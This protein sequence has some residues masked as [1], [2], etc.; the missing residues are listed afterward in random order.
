MVPFAGDGSGVD[1]L[2][3]GQRN[4]WRMME[5]IGTPEMVGGA[6]K[7]DE[8]TTVDNIRNLLSFI[9]SRHQSLR[10]RIRIDPDGVP[11]QW[12]SESGE[13]P[14]TIID[15]PDDEDPAEVAEATREHYE[16]APFDI[17]TEWPV[18]MAVV[19]HHGVPSHFAVQYPHMVI[20]GYGFEA[21]LRD[22]R[23][24]DQETGEVLGPR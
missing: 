14:L 13:V 19:R 18:R 7:L 12:L 16:T 2:T 3:W 23:N 1:D 17:G 21:L 24:L 8:G 5:F 15:V 22:L 11:K 10:T 6:M 20:D 4:I 9:V